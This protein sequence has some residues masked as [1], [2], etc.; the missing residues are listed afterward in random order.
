ML[1]LLWK[2]ISFALTHHVLLAGM[3][4]LPA[5]PVQDEEIYLVIIC[6]NFYHALIQW[7]E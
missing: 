2:I 5:A 4:M 6:L 3:G 7:I 1:W